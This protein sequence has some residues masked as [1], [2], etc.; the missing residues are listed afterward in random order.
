MKELSEY[1]PSSLRKNSYFLHQWPCGALQGTRAAHTHWA[2]LGQDRQTIYCTYKSRCSLFEMP[3]QKESLNT[4]QPGYSPCS[5]TAQELMFT[6]LL[7]SWKRKCER[8]SHTTIREPKAKNVWDEICP[9]SHT[10]WQELRM[11][12]QSLCC[13]ALQLNST[14]HL[15]GPWVFQQLLTSTEILFFI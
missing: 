3:G 4:R 15:F 7:Q 9:Y 5:Q 14:A 8:F 13:W 10:S 11:N 6:F 12:F 2:V 1:K